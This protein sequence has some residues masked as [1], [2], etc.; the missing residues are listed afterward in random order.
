MNFL[1][2]TNNLTKYYGEVKALSDFSVKIDSGAIGLLGP[3]GAG[4]STLIKILLGLTPAT[5]G[6]GK[7]FSWDISKE[8]LK[9]RQRIGYMPENDCFLLDLNA[10][11]YLSYLGQLSGLSPYDAMQRAHEALYYVKIGDERYREIETYSSGMKQKVK[12]AQA[13]LHDPELIF[14]DEPTTGLDPSGRREMLSLIKGIVKDQGKNILF[15]SH[16]LPDI[17]QTCDRVVI[18]NRGELIAQDKIKNLLFER[19]P[20]LVIR[21]RGD[22]N[23]FIN[24]L[25]SSG[26]KPVKRK[27]DILIKHAPNISSRVIEIAASTGVQLRH[28]S[29]SKRSLEELF[30][31]MIGQDENKKF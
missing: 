22:E 21:I 20:D 31:K 30:V 12:L 1:I 29:S 2:Q 24:E 18:L 19:K 16:I 14:L 9:I 26:L 23:R 6:T 5:S 8:G 4:K 7:V 17:E 15:S 25:K 11:S 27:N 13:L 10:V 28:F 3:N